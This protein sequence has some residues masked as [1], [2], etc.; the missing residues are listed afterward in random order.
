MEDGF[1]CIMKLIYSYKR[2][3]IL[4]FQVKILNMFLILWFSYLPLGTRLSE[5]FTL[6]DSNQ[7]EMV[8]AFEVSVNDNVNQ[9]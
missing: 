6:E 9:L 8:T 3:H 4:E 2:F 7:E 1:S 5:L